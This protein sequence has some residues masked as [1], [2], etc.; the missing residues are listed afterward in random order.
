MT[1]PT[2][3]KMAQQMAD[4]LMRTV[5]GYLGGGLPKVY[6]NFKAQMTDFYADLPWDEEGQKIAIQHILD[7][8]GD[9]LDKVK[10][11]FKFDLQK[12]LQSP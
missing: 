7:N 10:L 12:D 6:K 3:T 8:H 4:A 9:T 2:P 5:K 11:Q 1:T